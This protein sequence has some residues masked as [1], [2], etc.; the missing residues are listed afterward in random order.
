MPSPAC[1]SADLDACSVLSEGVRL[2]ASYGQ[3]PT[4]PF[5]HVPNKEAPRAQAARCR[6]HEL[7]PGAARQTRL[8]HAPFDAASNVNHPRFAPTS[9]KTD[10]MATP[11]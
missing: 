7:G 11:R 9:T 10:L 5:P 1:Q 4:A 6:V 8:P 2:L 3:D